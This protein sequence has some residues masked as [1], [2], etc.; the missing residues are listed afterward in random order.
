MQK[1]AELHKELEQWLRDK[2]ASILGVKYC[3]FILVVLTRSTT[4]S[5]TATQLSHRVSPADCQCHSTSTSKLNNLK[6][7]SHGSITQ[8][9]STTTHR[10]GVTLR[11]MK[12][13]FIL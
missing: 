8:A 13:S 12:R 6:T 11:I 2:L 4:T 3:N 5:K 9:S 10:W 1:A 7:G